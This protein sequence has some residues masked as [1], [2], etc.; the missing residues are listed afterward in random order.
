MADH[1]QQQILDA[2]KTILLAANT[3]ANTSVFLERVDELMESDLPAIHIEGGDEDVS[4]ESVNFPVIQYR[5]F[6]FT[7]SCIVAGADYGRAAR[8]LSKQVETAFLSSA[9]PLNGKASLLSLRGST[10]QKDGTGAVV[11]FEIRQQ[12][13]ATYYT[14]GAVPDALM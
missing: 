6:Q 14:R 12:W 13:Q 2:A 4:D 3:A 10:V 9:T 5:R 7:T 1:I 11:L 8:N